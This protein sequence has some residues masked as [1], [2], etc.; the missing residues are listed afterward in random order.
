MSASFRHLSLL[1]LIVFAAGCS[2]PPDSTATTATAA[3]PLHVTTAPVTVSNAASTVALPGTIRAVQRATVAAKTMGTVR[4]INFTLG[5]PV[6]SGQP[7]VSLAAEELTAAVSAA[8]AA[9]DL[10]N[11]E[12]ARET[13]LLAQG[14]TIED[15]VRRF[16]DQRRIAA[17][18]LDV[19]TAQL[20][21]TTVTAP[22][23][24]T[25]TAR[26]VEP[27]DLAA[28]GTPL[29]A[30]EGAAREVEVHVPA[31]LPPLALGDAVT[32][33]LPSGNGSATLRELSPAADPATRTRLARIVLPTNTS[34]H[35]GVFARVLWPT[36]TSAQLTIPTTAVATFGQM[37]R[38]FIVTADNRAALRLVKLG[39]VTADTAVILSG[40]A[41]GETVIVAPPAALRDGSPIL[42]NAAR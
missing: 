38:V 2:R 3:A 42:F 24:G 18:Q 12:L 8:R 7:L 31:S 41:L 4:E 10:V 40:L 34:A 36:P 11:R 20:A 16:E 14:A 25:I 32:V 26:H 33:S 1:G 17:A 22:F 21:H 5:Q 35:S 39:P 28:P 37:Q 27:G 29:F 30:L 23:A 13:A 9:L 15:N 6:T 19:V